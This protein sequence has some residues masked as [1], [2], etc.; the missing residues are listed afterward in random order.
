[1]SSTRDH[2]HDH[3]EDNNVVFID[4]SDIIHE[5]PSDDEVLPDAGDA[6]DPGGPP[7]NSSSSSDS[8]TD[9]GMNFYLN[10][11]K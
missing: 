3:E 11:F 2:D 8:D 7:G 6:D 1:M 5:V 10:I 4:Q 9:I